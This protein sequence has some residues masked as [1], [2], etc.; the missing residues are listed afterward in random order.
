MYP[1]RVE[2]N[3]RTLIGQPIVVGCVQPA[4]PSLDVVAPIVTVQPFGW[5]EAPQW[6]PDTA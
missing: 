2:G 3:Q 1:A 6:M 5:N 4:P